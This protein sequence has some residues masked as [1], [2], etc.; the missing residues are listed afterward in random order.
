VRYRGIDLSP[1]M[2]QEGRRVNPGLQL[3]VANILDLPAAEAYDFVVAQGIFYLLREDPEARMRQIVTRM[4]AVASEAIAF[5]AISAWAARRNPDEFYV[6][7]TVT[8]ELGHSLTKAVV[9]RHDYHPG[10]LTLYL[11]KQDWR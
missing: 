7:P 3:E 2:V 8:L 9:L 5:T 4:F 6:D 10:D 1:R 11:Y